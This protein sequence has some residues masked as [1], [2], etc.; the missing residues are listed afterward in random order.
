MKFLK[1][2][3]RLKEWV[4]VLGSQSEGEAFQLQNKTRGIEILWVLIIKLEVKFKVFSEFEKSYSCITTY[5]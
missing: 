2:A 1:A 5:T 4:D 3:I